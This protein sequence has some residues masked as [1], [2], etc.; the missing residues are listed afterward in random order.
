MPKIKSHLTDI[1]MFDWLQNAPDPPS[2]KRRMAIWLANTTPLPAEKIAASIKASPQA[3]WLW[4]RKYNQ[5][6]PA[7]LERRGRGGRR[8]AFM[9]LDAETALIGR[10]KHLLQT[11]YQPATA[12]IKTAVEQ[13]LGRR[14][15]LDYIYKLLQRH[16]WAAAIMRSKKY[17]P[18]F[19]KSPFEKQSHPWLRGS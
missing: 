6:G 1:K 11:G 8:W 3:V 16:N 19:K 10:F 12:D 9:P 13:K 15:S 14:V 18:I 7:G 17:A 4:I 2:Y 5:N